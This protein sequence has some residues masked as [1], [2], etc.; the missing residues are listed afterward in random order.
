MKKKLLLSITAM[1]LMCLNAFAQSGTLK[2]DVNDDGKVDVADINAIIKIMK[3]NGG[4]NEETMGKWYI[5]YI[6]GAS[7]KFSQ[8]Y[9]T[10]SNEF[11][12]FISSFISSNA[13]LNGTDNMVANN[14]T[15]QSGNSIDV[16]NTG[17]HPGLLW[18]IIPTSF[19][20]TITK[21]TNRSDGTYILCEGDAQTV[22]T[23]RKKINVNNIEY[24]IYSSR[25]NTNQTQINIF[26]S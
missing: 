6:D 2:G 24:N 22:I 3:E 5:G 9:H 23:I 25:N 13:M 21:I 10:G 17:T 18:F 20:N 12:T 15:V 19:T 8:D 11:D 4:T 7:E 14:Y 1:L 16:S 26:K